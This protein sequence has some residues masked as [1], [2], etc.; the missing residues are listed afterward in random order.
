MNSWDTETEEWYAYS[1]RYGR[2]RCV[3]ESLKDSGRLSLRK[4]DIVKFGKGHL[5]KD[6][7]EWFLTGKDKKKYLERYTIPPYNV[8]KYAM[9]QYG[10]VVNRYKITKYKCLTFRDYGSII[11]MITGKNILDRATL[12]MY[13]KR[14]TLF[15]ERQP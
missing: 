1:G 13:H 11:M 7:R 9:N 5:K 14:D 4:G 3:K 2:F 12:L 10:I 15:D 8:P 6:F